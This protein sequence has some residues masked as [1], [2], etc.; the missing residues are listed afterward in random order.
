MLDLNELHTC[1]ASST[2]CVVLF[3]LILIDIPKNDW[4]LS[5]MSGISLKNVRDPRYQDPSF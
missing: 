3:F 1:C 5:K 2:T 4:S